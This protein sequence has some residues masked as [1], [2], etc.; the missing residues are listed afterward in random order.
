MGNSYQEKVEVFQEEKERYRRKRDRMQDAIDSINSYLDNQFDGC[1]DEYRYFK[2][3]LDVG[4]G[5]E[6]WEGKRIVDI[7]ENMDDAIK[8]KLKQLRKA[9]EDIIE[10]MEVLAEYYETERSKSEKW[11]NYYSDLMDAEL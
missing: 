8:K 6:N 4:N 2:N 9:Y 10:Q 1:M 7:R 3:H 11:E 5:I